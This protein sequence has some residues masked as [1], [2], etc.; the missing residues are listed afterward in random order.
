[1][2]ILAAR[3]TC[4]ARL[5]LDKKGLLKTTNKVRKFFT[6][7]KF[8]LDVLLVAIIAGVS[9]RRRISSEFFTIICESCFTVAD[10]RIGN[11]LPVSYT[12]KK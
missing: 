4:R 9:Y 1:M 11:E 3:N 2:H 8:K 7:K 5:E 12:S 6:K 10:I